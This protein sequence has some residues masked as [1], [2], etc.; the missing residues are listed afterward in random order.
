MRI[1]HTSSEGLDNAQASHIRPSGEDRPVDYHN[2]DIPGYWVWRSGEK[3]PLKQLEFP[4]VN[5]N[6]GSLLSIT[7]LEQAE[8]IRWMAEG[9]E[10]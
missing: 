2:D 5:D 3:E 9:G 6:G 1:L 10:E 7:E 8:N 4:W